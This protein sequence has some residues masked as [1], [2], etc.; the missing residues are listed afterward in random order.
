MSEDIKNEVSEEITEEIKAA[1]QEEEASTEITKDNRT[2]FSE[3]ALEK[4]ISEMKDETA[5]V[6]PENFEF[7]EKKVD[8]K[9]RGKFFVRLVSALICLGV[10]LVNG[11]AMRMTEG[12]YKEYSKVVPD[13][14]QIIL[15]IASLYA[16]GVIANIIGGAKQEEY[17]VKEET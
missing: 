7:G 1:V 13:W 12:G 17:H 14:I 11:I 10:F 6:V 8:K 2:S 15:I 16:V 9:K 4:M 3:G 5:D